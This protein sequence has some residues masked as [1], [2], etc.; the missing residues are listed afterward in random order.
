MRRLPEFRPRTMSRPTAERP[1]LSSF[2]S[3]ETDSSGVSFE[4]KQPFPPLLPDDRA[5]HSTRMGNENSYPED[6]EQGI[7]SSTY[8]Q[9]DVEDD[10]DF[11]SHYSH[12]SLSE[13]SSD[14]DDQNN[15]TSSIGMQQHQQHPFR[16]STGS[17]HGPNA[18]APPFYNRPPTPLPPSPSLT[19]LLRPPFSATTSRP[20]T[21]DGS[22]VDT[23][24]DTEAAVAKSARRATTVPRASPKV[25][26]YEYY[27]FVLYLVSTLAFC[28]LM[29]WFRIRERCSYFSDLVFV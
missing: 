11:Q 29:P 17:L 19:S 26:T 27:G 12:E 23:P 21:P 13:A 6:D 4:S 22:D 15:N 14:S 3:R 28:K 18:F 8:D 1:Q 2:R 24:D 20:T 9:I 5:A 10:A 16:Q 7:V 25:P